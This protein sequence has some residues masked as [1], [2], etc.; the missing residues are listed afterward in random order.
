MAWTSPSGLTTSPLSEPFRGTA[1]ISGS[2]AGN[3][4]FLRS[5]QAVAAEGVRA[6]GIL[7]ASRITIT[8]Q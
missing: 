5:G 2:T 1:V 6:N 7:D 8:S 3:T 4:S